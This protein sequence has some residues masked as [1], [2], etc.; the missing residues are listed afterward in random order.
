MLKIATANI[1]D[2]KKARLMKAL[3]KKVDKSFNLSIKETK[4]NLKELKNQDIDDEIYS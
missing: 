1:E 3:E 4:K 2:E